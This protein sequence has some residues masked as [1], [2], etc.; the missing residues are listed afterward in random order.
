MPSTKNL[1]VA[2]IIF[3]HSITHAITISANVDASRQSITTNATNIFT[4]EYSTDKDKLVEFAVLAWRTNPVLSAESISASVQGS[5]AH[6]DK[7]GFF[8]ALGMTTFLESDYL[9]AQGSLLLSPSAS[10]FVS[11][12][13]Y[14]FSQNGA[15]LEAGATYTRF[16]TDIANQTTG[17]LFKGFPE[18]KLSDVGTNV[19]DF[20]IN[21][22]VPI[23]SKFYLY[24]GM[25]F[26]LDMFKSEIPAIAGIGTEYRSIL[27]TYNAEGTTGIEHGNLYGRNLSFA[28]NRFT[29]GTRFDITDVY[30]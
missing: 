19:I 21:I 8:G 6:T 11:A 28:I 9:Y 5:Y 1:M 16:T 7:Y 15:K 24:A 14:Y 29:V 18:T 12:G 4:P 22:S 2:S 10:P 23:V 26:G 17:A 27:T 25:H 20:G 30:E 13:G 3:I